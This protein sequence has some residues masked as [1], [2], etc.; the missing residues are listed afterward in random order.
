MIL[1]CTICTIILE[2][3]DATPF[4]HPDLHTPI[5]TNNTPTLHTPNTPIS[6][7]K[8]QLPQTLQIMQHILPHNHMNGTLVHD[9]NMIPPSNTYNAHINANPITTTDTQQVTCIAIYYLCMNI[10]L[11]H[12]LHTSPS[13][14]THTSPIATTTHK[15]TPLPY[16]IIPNA[17]LHQ[18]THLT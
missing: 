2:W 3:H 8:I 6:N 4:G 10:I 11:S 18:R 9:T 17:G 5:I 7:T 16:S 13:I 1:L 14:P 12:I 15:F